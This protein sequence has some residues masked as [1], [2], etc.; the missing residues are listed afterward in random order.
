MHNPAW[1]ICVLGKTA[2][3]RLIMKKT[4]LLGAMSLTLIG[5]IGIVGVFLFVTTNDVINLF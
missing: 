3:E 2:D 5:L 4:V 1:E